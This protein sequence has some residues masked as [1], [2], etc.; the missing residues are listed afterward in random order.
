MSNL[1]NN[2]YK[3]IE[4]IGEGSF[5]NIFK[6]LNIRTREN[7]VVKIESILG[8]T[9]LLKH[10]TIVY[11][12]LKGVHGVPKIKWYGK[13]E[14]NYYMVLELLGPSIENV[15]SKTMNFSLR[16]TLT[17]GLKVLNLLMEIHEKGLIHRDVKPDNFLFGKPNRTNKIDTSEMYIIDFGFCKSFIENENHIPFKKTHG[18]IGS[19]S[20]ASINAHD[21]NELSRRDD[22]ESLAYMMI[23]LF[24]EK[25]PWQDIKVS[26]VKER[27]VIMKEA[28]LK[29]Q[30]DPEIHPAFKIFLYNARKLSFED[31]PN[32]NEMASILENEL[33]NIIN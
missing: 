31:T 14:T 28:K 25:L 30:S 13:D 32:Y 7:V 5:G 33:K 15:K 12:Y 3:I 27:N 18:L 4:K 17:I 8:E 9:K 29:I 10:E 21:L 16:S 24:H 2:K 11:Q 1:I 22:I 23:Y 20:F 6:A 19:P 26:N